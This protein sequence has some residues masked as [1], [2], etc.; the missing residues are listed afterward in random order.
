MQPDG[1]QGRGPGDEAAMAGRWRR[2]EESGDDSDVSCSELE[3]D[4]WSG[5]DCSDDGGGGSS[6]GGGGEVSI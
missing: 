1:G 2:D 5:S 3:D 6:G 4:E